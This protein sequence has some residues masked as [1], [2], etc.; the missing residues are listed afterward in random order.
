[1]GASGLCNKFKTDMYPIHNPLL[2]SLH[3]W[4]EH[5]RKAEVHINNMNIDFNSY[6]VRNMKQLRKVEINIIK[7]V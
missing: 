1:M 7:L 2:K 5:K 6:N 4:W 3:S